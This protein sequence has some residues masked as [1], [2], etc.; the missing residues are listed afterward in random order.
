[1]RC[2]KY[3]PF[4]QEKSSVN[5]DAQS[6]CVAKGNT[7]QRCY[8]LRAQCDWDPVANIC[9]AGP[10]PTCASLDQDTVGCAARS[11]CT[12]QGYNNNQCADAC[13]QL[14]AQ[15]C[16]GTVP[17]RQDCRLNYT[18][19]AFNCYASTAYI[20]GCSN[21]IAGSSCTASGCYFDPY[22]QNCFL[23]QTQFKTVFPCSYFAQRSDNA[24]S[25]ESCVKLAD[26]SC[27]NSVTTANSADNSTSINY[28]R[29]I[30]FLN[31]RVLPNSQTFQ[32]TI[33]VPFATSATPQN[34][35]PY[36][37]SWPIFKILFP[38]TNVGAYAKQVVPQCSSQS[39][40]LS[41]PMTLNQVQVPN[42]AALQNYILSTVRASANL[43]FPDSASLGQQANA[44]YG[45]PLIGPSQLIT[46]VAQT[47]NDTTLYFTLQRDLVTLT[48][49]CSAFGATAQVNPTNKVYTLPISYIEQNPQNAFT[50]FTILYTITITNSGTVTVGT[51]TN[52]HEEA[53]PLQVVFPTSLCPLNQARMQISWQLELHDVF[54]SSRVIGPRSVSDVSIRSPASL[55][56]PNNCFQ[57]KIINFQNLG[58]NYNGY[59]CTYVITTESNCRA[60]TND[61]NAFNG[62]A[63]AQDA[64]RLADMGGNF[65]YPQ[66]LDAYHEFYVNNY[67]C[68]VA[69]V[70]DASC[71]LITA[72]QFNL[73]DQIRATIVTSQ[74]LENRVAINPFFVQAGF[75][76]TPIAS[77]GSA[78]LVT[79][80]PGDQFGL[81]K[82]E[83]NLFSSQ[84]LTVVIQLPALSVFDYDLRLMLE[85]DNVTFT[86]LDQA[87]VPIGNSTLVRNFA[88]FRSSLLYT[89]K[90]DFDAGCGADGSCKLLPACLGVRGCDGFSIGSVQLKALV[91]ANGYRFALNYRV[92][93]S[94]VGPASRRLLQQRTSLRDAGQI[95]Y[96]VVFADDSLLLQQEE[97]RLRQQCM[98]LSMEELHIKFMAKSDSSRVR[99]ALLWSA[100]PVLFSSASLYVF[101]ALVVFQRSRHAAVHHAFD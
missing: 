84:P 18:A 67:N 19:N 29:K 64:D 27:V 26:N 60:L 70:N 46:S 83:G 75:L 14:T 44:V 78:S 54:D 57:D 95:F 37:P 77:L 31:P 92:D 94:R 20:D 86:P 3:V 51:S 12:V 71:A 17:I 4:I 13:A 6:F 5:C 69:R 45:K 81:L 10:P 30:F 101:T 99:N 59:V 74:Y 65:S 15:R 25:D 7:A 2:L 11:E 33:G 89:S 48:A 90:T 66:A 38:V 68:P 62:C 88:S 80:A 40:S 22:L 49:Q 43:T 56:G 1:M 73:P 58:C 32:L 9:N 52:Y 50:Q 55:P 36:N 8:A 87:G 24:C 82:Y 93:V 96:D 76:P 47:G 63:Y 42:A 39:D 34:A 16:V 35:W 72:S 21:Q 79:V 100:L 28:A 97:E 61:G 85:Y 53:F 98:S 23:T 41:A 91:P